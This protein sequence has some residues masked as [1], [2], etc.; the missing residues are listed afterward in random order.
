MPHSDPK[1]KQ[2]YMREYAK[3]YRVTEHGKAKLY[4]NTK[5]WR[6]AHWHKH[7]ATAKRYRDEHPERVKATMKRI[8]AL[9]YRV[10]KRL[11]YW[12]KLDPSI[13]RAWQKGQRL[14]R[15]LRKIKNG[16]TCSIDQWIARCEL[17]G[18]CCGYCGS[19]TARR[20]EIDHIIPIAKGGTG[21]ASN[22]VPACRSCNARKNATRW[23]TRLPQPKTNYFVAE[24]T[25]LPRMVTKES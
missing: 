15:S 3:R 6:Q 9:P 22:L 23:H 17:Y 12:K 25:S 14:R 8:D 19:S 7:L 21:W 20:L 10:E 24:V 13:L 11:E 1:K 2:E 16:G 5:K 4:A 18:Y